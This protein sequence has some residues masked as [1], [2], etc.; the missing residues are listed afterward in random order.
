M[1]GS[2]R[3]TTSAQ[4]WT[5]CAD[6]GRSD[7]V[8]RVCP[9]GA[10]DGETVTPED[11]QLSFPFNEQAETGSPVTGG[12]GTPVAARAPEVKRREQPVRRGAVAP[13]LV[14]F[15]GAWNASS[16]AAAMDAACA[17]LRRR[18]RQQSGPYALTPILEELSARRA[19]A[20]PGSGAHGRLHAHSR[21]W[22]VYRREDMSWRR[23]RFTEAHEIAHILLYETLADDRR[24]L[25]DLQNRQSHRQIEELCDYGA[26]ELL[27]P[28][29]DVSD[30]LTS[31]P[32]RTLAD[33]NR[34]YDTYLVSHVTLLRRVA[35]LLPR[36]VLTAWQYLQH[37]RGVNWRIQSSYCRTV[38]GVYLPPGLSR[39]HLRPDLVTQ[40]LTHGSAYAAEA[41]IE[42]GDRHYTGK[43][44]AVR[45][46]FRDQGELP[47]LQ[48]RPVRDETADDTVYVL[49]GDLLTTVLSRPRPY[50]RARGEHDFDSYL[51]RLPLAKDL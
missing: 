1:F 19:K 12:A 4:R 49:H 32:L 50:R 7:P 20:R 21:G 35:T 18:T 28:V 26:A 42:V 23:V 44:L 47:I 46:A 39:R 25:S 14:A 11:P 22:T 41:T 29:G 3:T 43:M 6:H 48:G 24:A 27:V 33:Y 34:L 13:S 36:T 9:A 5:P 2:T 15:A 40:A 51:Q 31:N 30:Y 37:R 45:P 17:D 38:D 10:M 8:G 16:P